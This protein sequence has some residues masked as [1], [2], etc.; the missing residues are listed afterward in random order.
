VVSAGQNKKK[1]G[2]IPSFFF[3]LRALGAQTEDAPDLLR[4]GAFY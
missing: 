1:D 2:A 4:S 3:S